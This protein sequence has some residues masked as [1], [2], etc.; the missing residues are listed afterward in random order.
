M[1]EGN[2]EVKVVKVSDG[3]QKHIDGLKGIAC[4]MIMVGHYLGIVKFTSGMPGYSLGIVKSI[5][6]ANW[7]MFLDESIWL[8]LF[9]VISG[10]LLAMSKITTIK[11]L[12]KKSVKRFL[13][14]FLPVLGACVFIYILYV[15]VGFHNAETKAVF[16]NTWFQDYYYNYAFSWKDI[17]IEPI[18]IVLG[19]GTT[20][21]NAPY[22]CIKAMFY[23]SI[24]IYLATW[25]MKFS[26]KSIVN[27]GISIVVTII[28]KLL[29]GEIGY[30][31]CLGM[32][33]RKIVEMDFSFWE[34]KYISNVMVIG[35]VFLVF[36]LH[37]TIYELVTRVIPNIPSVLEYSV[38]WGIFYFAILIIASNYNNYVKRLLT[39][40]LFMW[41]NSISF[42][43]YSLHW[44]IVCSVGALLILLIKGNMGV[45]ACWCISGVLTLVSAVLYN[46]VV[47]KTV[48][49]WINRI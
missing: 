12:G 21:F 17:F 22:W 15:F 5:T 11:Q 28:A 48:F 33:S 26:K 42:G 20:Y 34:N 41:L 16:T 46:L 18:K 32:I 7:G 23:S 47:E 35:S 43:I 14:L 29:L 45:V 36:G 31:C 27:L 4:V 3:R 38:Q 40:K 1:K 30:A 9:F 10:Y 24:I 49:K 13:R 39:N 44:P 25:L 8:R 19:G 6:N 37:S 2:I